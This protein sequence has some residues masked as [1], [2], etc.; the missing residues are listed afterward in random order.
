MSPLWIVIALVDVALC[1]HVARTKRPIAWIFVILLFPVLGALAYFLAEVL[2]GSSMAAARPGGEA[3]VHALDAQRRRKLVAERPRL[4]ER[5][6][7]ADTVENRL[8][9]ADA[10]IAERA[11][12]RAAALYAACLTGPLEHDPRILL[13]LAR[14]HFGLGKYKAV[15]RSLETLVGANP[16]F[17][18][19]DGHLLYARTLE[20]LDEHDAALAE[21]DALDAT[22]PGEEARYR[23]G[24]LLAGLGRSADARA[25]FEHVLR[26]ERAAPE[27]YRDRERMWIDQ[28]RAA[29]DQL[30]V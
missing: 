21:Y 22:F 25:V 27:H 30:R 29:L 8:A 24:S 16:G 5:L 1:V 12:E 20:Q 23:H 9:V 4:E 13:G 6:A 19:P 17:R 14:A 15:R 2:G 28:S 3:T 18:S 26:N 7:A 10:C 11:Y